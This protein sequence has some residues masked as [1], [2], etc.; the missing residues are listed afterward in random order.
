MRK[1]SNDHPN[2]ISRAGNNVR[3]EGEKLST[4][5]REK[6]TFINW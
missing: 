3:Y 1:E 4:L 5:V 6:L 2:Q